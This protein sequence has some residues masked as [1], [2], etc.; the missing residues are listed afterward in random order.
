M[1][2]EEIMEDEVMY[3]WSINT[4]SRIETFEKRIIENCSITLNAPLEV[5]GKLVFRNCTIVRTSGNIAVYGCLKIQNCKINAEKPFLKVLENGEYLFDLA[6]FDAPVLCT[7]TGK[8]SW[9]NDPNVEYWME[10]TI[11]TCVAEYYAIEKA[12]L[13]GKDLTDMTAAEK[14][15]AKEAKI[16]S[17]WLK[18]KI[19]EIPMYK[20]S[21]QLRY[22]TYFAADAWK[23]I[24]TAIENGDRQLWKNI[25]EMEATISRKLYERDLEDE[26]TYPYRD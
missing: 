3:R 19:L 2:I 23:E 10:D 20:I 25:A 24:Q 21:H 6:Y 4:H 15:I 26:K 8:L 18:M 9:I 13:C 22:P 5:Y 17:V 1:S 16:V 12:W 14:K 7:K 11:L